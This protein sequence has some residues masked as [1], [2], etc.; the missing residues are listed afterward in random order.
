M[1]VNIIISFRA[2]KV[3]IPLL[4]KT[5]VEKIKSA[6]VQSVNTSNESVQMT[7]Q[8]IKILHKGKILMD[9][10]IDLFTLLTQS[11]KKLKKDVKL[12]AMGVSTTEARK[13]NQQFKEGLLKAPRIRDDITESGE[14]DIRRR[15]Q[16]GR[17]IMNEASKNSTKVKS[18]E[19]KFKFHRIETLPMLPDQK[20]AKEILTQ[21]ANDPGILACMAKHEWNVGCL[22]ELYPEGKVGE[23]AVCVM[24]LNQN[25]GQKLLLRIR[26]DDLSGFRKILS[27]RKVLFHELAHNVHSEHDSKF[28]QLMRQIE[29]ECI[30]MDW[31]QGSGN[32]TGNSGMSGSHSKNHDVYDH[33]YMDINQLYIGGSGRLGGSEY[34]KSSSHSN[35]LS[36]RE[37]TAKAAMQ[38]MTTEEEEIQN[39]CG[40]GQSQIIS[41][42]LNSRLGSQISSQT[43]ATTM[44]MERNNKE[45]NNNKKA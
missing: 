19:K 34:V 12:I 10:A 43:T 45:D 5:T 17:R 9:D 18:T 14:R 42:G 25:K 37:L 11:S 39:N 24:G 13:A 30:E 44:D 29:R 16:L 40:C 22:A 32:A 35:T 38:R 15:L 28:F 3:T 33:N 4:P 41:N 7:N 2:S 23:S 8:D 1:N 27:I 21:L 20:Q 31:T 6:L 36:L 26:T